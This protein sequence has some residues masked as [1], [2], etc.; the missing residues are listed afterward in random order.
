MAETD[1]QLRV[2]RVTATPAA[3]AALARLREQRGA[4]ILY[5]SG[6]CCDGSL[7]VCL[8]QGD[9]R[10]GDGDVLLG[11]VGGC[12]VYIDDRQYAVWKH[13][14]LIIDAGEGEPEGFSL[15]T[16]DGRHFVTRS[17]VFSPAELAAL[18]VNRNQGE[19]E[20]SS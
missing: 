13:T 16:G 14:Q 15:P 2:D 10:I 20:P 3:L 5:Q 8:E 1:G 19:G 18:P 12:P 4:L 7:P 11:S 6:G 9:L 17:R